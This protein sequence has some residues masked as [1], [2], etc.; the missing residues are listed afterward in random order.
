MLSFRNL[1]SSTAYTALGSWATYNAYEALKLINQL[2]EKTF[3]ICQTT[4]NSSSSFINAGCISIVK[5]I[6]KNVTNICE[7]IP[8]IDV[9]KDCSNHPLEKNDRTYF[10][11]AACCTFFALLT[12]GLAAKKAYNSFHCTTTQ[13]EHSTRKEKTTT[14][15]E[16]V[17]K[18]SNTDVTEKSPKEKGSKN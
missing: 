8:T 15:T 17:I 3:C 16:P 11:L 9:S 18:S 2:P 6:S 12:L 13:Q 14:N 4:L 1:A 5:L 10:S 7:Q